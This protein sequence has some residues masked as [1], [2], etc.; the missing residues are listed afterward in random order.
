MDSKIANGDENLGPLGEKAA[1][2]IFPQENK[3][4]NK[5]IELRSPRHNIKNTHTHTHT[6]MQWFL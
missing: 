3:K 6:C 2:F 5:K 4:K 1:F